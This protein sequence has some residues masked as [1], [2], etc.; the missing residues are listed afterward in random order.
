[1]LSPDSWRL[2]GR[3]LSPSLP[4]SLAASLPPSLDVDLTFSHR[5]HRILKAALR[6]HDGLSGWNLN[7]YQRTPIGAS[8]SSHA[9][10]TFRHI[11][12]LPR[13]LI[14]SDSVLRR[15]TWEPRAFGAAPKGRSR[16]ILGCL[17]VIR[18]PSDLLSVGVSKLSMDGML[19]LA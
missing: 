6:S 10:N 16:R 12:R 19:R 14:V 4:Q 18:V 3:R 1:M 8:P 5:Y 7:W 17:S 15:L 2:A 9:I 13:K 11:T